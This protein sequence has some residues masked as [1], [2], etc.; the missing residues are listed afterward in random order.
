MRA[1]HHPLAPHCHMWTCLKKQTHPL[2]LTMPAHAHTLKLKH[3]IRHTT[4]QAFFIRCPIHPKAKGVATQKKLHKFSLWAKQETGVVTDQLLDSTSILI[5]ATL[6]NFSLS[7]KTNKEG[8]YHGGSAMQNMTC[9]HEQSWT[10]IQETFQCSLRH[11]RLCSITGTRM[12]LR[13]SS[14]R[15]TRDQSKHLL[16]LQALALGFFFF[17]GSSAGQVTKAFWA[18]VL[19]FNSSLPFHSSL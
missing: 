6:R 13:S 2:P 10:F 9:L 7:P 4:L 19:A 16:S 11:R 1:I 3:T 12:S 8:L 14:A 18:N 17:P 15:P 5:D